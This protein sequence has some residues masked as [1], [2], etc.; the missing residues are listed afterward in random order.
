[1]GSNESFKS[2]PEDLQKQ[3]E[4]HYKNEFGNHVQIDSLVYPAYEVFILLI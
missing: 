4:N 1:M 3:L 2:F